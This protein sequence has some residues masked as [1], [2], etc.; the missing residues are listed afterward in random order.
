LRKPRLLSD[1][2]VNTLRGKA[3][4]GAMSRDDQ[5]SLCEHVT[6]LEMELDKRDDHF[7]PDGW[8]DAFRI[9]E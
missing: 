2:E 4:V 5:L 1:D 7:G 9:P 3:L 8:R 6:F